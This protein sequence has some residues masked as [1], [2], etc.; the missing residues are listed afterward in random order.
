MKAKRAVWNALGI[1]SLTGLVYCLFAYIYMQRM[2]TPAMA[3]LTA[4]LRT[5]S[6]LIPPF[7]LLAGI[8]HLFLLVDALKA[9]TGKEERSWVHSV[10]LLCIVLSGL[11][12]LSD[13]TLLSDIGKEYTLFDVRQEWRMVYG[14]T[15]F[16]LAVTLW[17]VLFSFRNNMS[18]RS[19]LSGMIQG[20]DTFFVAIHRIGFLCGLL[21]MLSVFLATTD[22]ID[23][24]L[25]YKQ[26]WLL[27]LSGLSIFPLVLVIIYWMVR[28]RKRLVSDW[29]DEK[30]MQDTAIG[31]MVAM[32]LF[33]TAL[34]VSGILVLLGVLAFP[35]FFWL[36][37][38][39]FICLT[40]FSLTVIARNPAADRRNNP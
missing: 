24:A 4:T 23:V 2:L 8:Y 26:Y 20:R 30:Q 38:L 17:G 37:L 33:M 16:H 9:L 7:L 29:L 40:G 18:R 12:L 19:L 34:I 15:G 5:L 32:A 35:T 10:Y 36:C 39:F 25:Q 11:M 27:L 21:G 6:W 13:V 28:N 1:L 3:D 14:F 31:A 22:I